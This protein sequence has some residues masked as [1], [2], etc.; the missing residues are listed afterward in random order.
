MERFV[1]R[2]LGEMGEG[3]LLLL[4]LLL[5]MLLLLLVNFRFWPAMS[6]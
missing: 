6:R 4:L 2:S 3:A 1:G 5:L